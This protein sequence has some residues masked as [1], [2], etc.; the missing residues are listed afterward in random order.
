MNSTHSTV[1]VESRQE[2]QA[3][4]TIRKVGIDIVKSAN[5]ASRFYRGPSMRHVPILD[6]SDLWARSLAKAL[7]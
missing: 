5:L 2:S 6:E 3:S 7:R 1:E 4:T